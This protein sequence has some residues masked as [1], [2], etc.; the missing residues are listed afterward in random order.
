MRA[1]GFDLRWKA[2]DRLI[3]VEDYRRVA[4]RRLPHMVWN[5]VDGGAD[6]LVSLRDNREAFARWSL[7]TRALAG[8]E[9]RELSTTVAGVP[10]ELPVLLAPTGLTGLTYWAGDIVAT[11][12]AERH[13]TRYVLSTVSS[14]SIEEVAA[15]S[16]VDHFFQ[17]YPRSGEVGASL[18][19]RAWNAGMRVMVVTVDVP[20]RGNREGER[21]HGLAVPPVLTPRRLFN[22]ASHPRWAY[23]VLRHQRIAARNL[24]PGDPLDGSGLAQAIES[25]DIQTRQLMQPTLDWDDLAWMREQWKGPLYVKGIVD[26]EDAKR[27]VTLGLDGIVVSNHGGRQLD[28]A[29]AALDALPDIV[30]AVGDR[31]EILFDGGVRRGTDVIKALALGARAVLIGRPY[32]YGM[33]VGGERGVAHVLDILKE[34]IDR[35]LTLMGAQSIHELDPSWLIRR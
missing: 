3:A 25:V 5:Y 20:I 10:V 21:R 30:A 28:F 17:L 9:H 18:M 31:A 29:P 13:G 8:H 2:S 7:R 24:P 6:D 23:G 16:Q 19:K 22:F 27:A 26:P 32:L 11:R 4:R 33:A 35:D 34:E 15:A 1:F 14:W 12:A